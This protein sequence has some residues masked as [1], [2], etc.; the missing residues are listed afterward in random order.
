MIL[1]FQDPGTLVLLLD[2]LLLVCGG[3]AV[4]AVFGGILYWL[5]RRR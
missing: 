1:L 4:L 5:R 3:T 2:P